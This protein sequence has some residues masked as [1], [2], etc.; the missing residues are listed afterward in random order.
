MNKEYIYNDGKVTIIDELGKM[1]TEEYYDNI[2]KVLTEE[3]A[4]EIMEKEIEKIKNEWKK[5][6]T[7]KKDK[8]LLLVPLLGGGIISLIAPLLI[9]TTITNQNIVS[10]A[11]D[12]FYSNYILS[13]TSMVLPFGLTFGGIMSAMEYI[14]YK[15]I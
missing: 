3:N 7:N 14:Q 9:I 10:L 15:K 2:D 1:K 12:A 13:L 11:N 5:Y 8:L 6:E 4:I